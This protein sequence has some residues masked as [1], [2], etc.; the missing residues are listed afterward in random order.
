MRATGPVHEVIRQLSAD[1]RVRITIVG[2]QERAGVILEALAA[3]RRV[4]TADGA[5]EATYEGDDSTAAEILHALTAE[6][7]RVSA[8]SQ[9]DGGLEE[10]FMRATSE[11]V[12]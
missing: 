12:G 9:V 7:I 4:E 2:D 5:I 11:E 6:G 10:A 1:R 3:V 8:F